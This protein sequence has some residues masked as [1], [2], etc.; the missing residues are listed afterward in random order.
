[1][2][3]PRYRANLGHE[4][5]RQG[6]VV[7]AVERQ[8][9]DGHGVAHV[10]VL[11]L[12]DDGHAPGADPL[13]DAVVAEHQPVDGAGAD[14]GGL[15]LGQEAVLDEQRQDRFPVAAAT[16]RVVELRPLFLPFLRQDD[17][18]FQQLVHEMTRRCPVIGARASRSGWAGS[19]VTGEAEKTGHRVLFEGWARFGHC[20]PI[21]F[22]SRARAAAAAS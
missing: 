7:L 20:D 17:P 2:A 14:P 13:E 6:R 3:Q 10:D 18:R 12:E 21:G 9:L 19:R 1:M 11:A 15:I 5:A 16:H 4:P 8:H 22:G